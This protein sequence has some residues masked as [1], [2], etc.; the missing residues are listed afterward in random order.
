MI[1]QEAVRPRGTIVSLSINQN[2]SREAFDFR[3][4]I[5]LSGT[6]HALLLWII[7]LRQEKS[8]NV[9]NK[10]NEKKETMRKRNMCDSHTHDE[11]AT[12]K[13]WNQ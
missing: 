3:R 4:F 1:E 5:D 13:R 7:L 12:R 10:I 2:N 9:A 11:D 6:S 8:P